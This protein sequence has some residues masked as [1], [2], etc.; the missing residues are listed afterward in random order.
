MMRASWATLKKDTELLIFPVLSFLA[1]AL[2][3]ASFALPWLDEGMMPFLARAGEGDPLFYLWTFLFYL[4]TSFVTIFFNAA[5]VGC[6]LAR[7]T[8]D[9]PT[10]RFG[11]RLAWR[12]LPQILGWS[13]ATGTVGFLLRM[14]EERV[15][16]A[17]RVVTSVLGMAWSV[18]SFL[19]VPVLV[20][21]DVGPIDA[22]RESVSMLKE[23]WG[24]QIA[25]SVSFSLLFGALGGPPVVFLVLLS[26]Q[27]GLVTLGVAL[28]AGGA[29]L[30]L[31]VLVFATLQSIFQAAVYA[32]AY[33][34][35]APPAF[36]EQA[37]SSS[38][39]PK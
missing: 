35:S 31:L 20:H 34:G 15:G 3:V 5:I 32:Y 17:G 29:Y 27:A 1:V 16:T 39:R 23:T 2:L 36:D 24:A 19:V 22:Y 10:V 4:A 21:R 37:L 33:A 6:A 38:F 26:A 9:D 12:N 14:V 13:L 30:I 18:T 28:A 8:G 11:L 7:M 25:G